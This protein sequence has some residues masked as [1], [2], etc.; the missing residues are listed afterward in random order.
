MTN[1]FS[2]H[3]YLVSSNK[4][5][6]VQHGI[7]SSG[8]SCNVLHQFEDLALLKHWGKTK[9]S[10]SDKPCMELMILT[11][12]PGPI[13]ARFSSSQ[14][15][16][17]KNILHLY[18]LSLTSKTWSSIFNCLILDFL[19]KNFNRIINTILWQNLKESNSFHL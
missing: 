1:I 16:L 12:C 6:L 15:T 3:H 17:R 18:F 7:P 9:I 13:L 11:L 2:F 19:K 4:I 5:M 8:L 10:L 14:K